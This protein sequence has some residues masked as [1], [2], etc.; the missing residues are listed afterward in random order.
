M[1]VCKCGYFVTSY[2]DFCFLLL[3]WLEVE[4]ELEIF[5]YHVFLPDTE[6]DCVLADTQERSDTSALKKKEDIS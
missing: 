2:R 4:F 6:C 5:W 1:E 3:A